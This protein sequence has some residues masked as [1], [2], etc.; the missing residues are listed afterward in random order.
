[1]S[2]IEL[3]LQRQIIDLRNQIDVLKMIQVKNSIY[4]WLRDSDTWVYVSTTQFKIVGK[5]V[6]A[7]FPV[8]TKIK[9]TQTTT[10]YFY[11]TA[12][13]FSTDTTVTITGGSDYSLA[14]ATITDPYYSYAATPQGFPQW[15]S[16]TSTVTYVGGTTDPTSLTVEM[17]FSVIGKLVFIRLISTLMRGSGD[18]TYIVHTLPIS[19]VVATSGSVSITFSSYSPCHNYLQSGNQWA[20]Y[21]NTMSSDGYGFGTIFYE[22][23]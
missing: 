13:A 7:K 19:Y 6:A 17:K 16:Y 18:R 12:A 9:L 15:F 3:E 11:V 20:W 21:V 22:I 8:G 5:D 23:A 14:N 10:K 2:E 4:G 1:M